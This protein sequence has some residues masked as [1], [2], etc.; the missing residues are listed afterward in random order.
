MSKDNKLVDFKPRS[1]KYR[2]SVPYRKYAFH[3][4]YNYTLMG[5]VATATLL[6]Q[7]WW[8]GIVGAGMEVLWVVFAPD[9]P[10][11]QRL[12]FDKVHDKKLAEI[13]AKQRKEILD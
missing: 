9:S 4:V 2:E 11:L 1:N 13:A 6:T 3:N 7:N 10:L 8:L 12:V 5:G